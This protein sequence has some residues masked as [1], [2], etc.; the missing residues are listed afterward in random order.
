[1]FDEAYCRIRTHAIG[2]IGRSKIVDVPSAQSG[3]QTW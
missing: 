3:V 1:V 2:S